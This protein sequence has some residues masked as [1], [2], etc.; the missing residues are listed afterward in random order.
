MNSLSEI[1]MN[2]MSKVGIQY[3]DPIVLTRGKEGFGD[4][5]TNVAMQV[6]KGLLS[7]P[8]EVGEK[9]V[10]ELVG[11]TAISRAEVAGPG[12]INIWTSDKW[13]E[14]QLELPHSP[15][16]ILAGHKYII[17]YSSPN[18]AKPM[19]V[20]HLRT[21][22]LG[23]ALVNLYRILGADVCAWS[24][25]GDWGVQ[26][27]KLIV[28]WKKWGNEVALRENPIDELLRV[29][30]KFH[31]EAKEHPELDD[32]GKSV[33]KAL[34]NGDVEAKRYWNEFTIY[35]Q[36][37]FDATYDRLRVKFDVWKGESTYNDKLQ[38]VVERALKCGAAEVSEG[39]VVIM[40]DDYNLPPLLIRKSDGATLY[41]T[42]DLALIEA[43]SNQIGVEELITVV[44][45]EQTLYLQQIK[46]A[47]EKLFDFE[48]FPKEFKMPKFTHVSHG[49]FRLVTGKMST[50]QGDLIKLND[51]LDQAV[52]K[53]T[54]VLEEKNN[55]LE[56]SEQKELSEE[57]GVAAVKYTD[58]IHDRHTD[59]VFDWDNMFS[60]TGNSIVYLFYTNARCNSLLSKASD[61]ENVHDQDLSWTENEK[62]VVMAAMMIDEAIAKSVSNYDPHFIL[63]HCYDLASLFSR[64]YNTDKIL[65][66]G[67]KV[68]ERRI[69]I[70]K[71]VQ[72]QLSLMFE[73]LG[74]NPPGKI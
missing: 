31:Q 48:Y 54:K 33:F 5:S 63:E 17:E 74:I 10:G 4:Y 36:K 51:V 43:K 3:S 52:Q 8:R 69:K 58:L 19:H 29:Y 9:I 37:E 47:A 41:G 32:E 71:L 15:T 11:E 26:F 70:V 53:A 68:R 72:S 34:Q 59:V 7:T 42:A 50:R 35:S 46:A 24:H 30:V 39:A 22:I 14:K 27:G 23:Q 44:G 56:S 66:V 12:F 65:K 45:N 62:K 2:A 1:I 25:P 13:L 64:F 20:G 57:I 21:T 28:G 18:I 67:P 60:L 73:I 16:K 55:E 49:F 40:L 6:A 38:N 61:A